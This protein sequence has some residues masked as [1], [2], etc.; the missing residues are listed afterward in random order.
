[1]ISTFSRCH[2]STSLQAPRRTPAP[3]ISHVPLKTHSHVTIREY[4]V[5][6]SQVA[7]YLQEKVDEDEDED[8]DNSYNGATNNVSSVHVVFVV[9]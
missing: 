5:T 6:S 4:H 1:M 3:T 7:K 8:A 9:S 2:K